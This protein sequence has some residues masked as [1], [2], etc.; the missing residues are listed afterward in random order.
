[1][2]GRLSSFRRVIL[3]PTTGGNHGLQVIARVKPRLSIDQ[4]RSDLAALSHRIVEQHPEYPYKDFN[5]TINWVLMAAVALVLLIACVNVAN[6]LLVRASAREREIAMRQALG[7]SR[8][9][10]N[11]APLRAGDR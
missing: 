4:A 6:L 1:M 3:D 2:S 9:G 7:I 11:Q 10:L 5:F 8:R